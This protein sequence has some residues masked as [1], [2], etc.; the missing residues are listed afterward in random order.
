MKKF[1]NITLIFVLFVI[2]FFIISPYI[3]KYIPYSKESLQKDI[4]FLIKQLKTH[5]I[6][7]FPLFGVQVSKKMN[8]SEFYVFFD[9]K[10]F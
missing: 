9:F 2:I 3:F 7:E 5:Y 6:E 1:I 8:V 10:I 4:D